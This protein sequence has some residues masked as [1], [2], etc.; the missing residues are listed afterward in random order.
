[1]RLRCLVIALTLL[2]T[3][4]SD[5]W[6]QSKQLPPSREK[7]SQTIEA[8]P[9]KDQSAAASDQRGTK[10]QPIIVDVIKPAPD[11]NERKTERDER[12]KKSSSDW[13]LNFFTALLAAFTFLLVSAAIAQIVIFVRQLRLIK[14][15]LGPAEKAANSA[16]AAA[17]AA[18]LNAQ[19]VVDAERARIYVEVNGVELI[20]QIQHSINYSPAHTPEQLQ[21]PVRAILGVVYAVKNYGRT[22][23]IIKEISHQLIVAKTLPNLPRKTAPVNPFPMSHFLARETESGITCNFESVFTVKDTR[24]VFGSLKTVWLY[25]HIAYDDTFGWGR[26]FNYVWHY[27][28]GMNDFRLYSFRETKSRE[29][30]KDYTD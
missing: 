9:T 30:H 6:G 23:A 19:A 24:E 25:G 12:D 10:A 8:K 26:E 11:E 21:A 22:P 14:D 15:S 18:K 28:G 27:N 2:S 13:W 5:S 3:I 29:R 16:A 7:D 20:R 17:D 1:M 4:A